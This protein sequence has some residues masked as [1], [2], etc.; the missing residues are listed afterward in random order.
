L[1]GV[2]ASFG[3]A[4]FS[5]DAPTPRAVVEAADAAMYQSKHAGR[6]RVS[7]SPI[8]PLVSD[9]PPDAAA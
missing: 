3:V 6:N 9:V 1:A 4:G 2:T 7:Q 8:A 5:T